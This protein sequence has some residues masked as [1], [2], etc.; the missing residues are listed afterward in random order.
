MTTEH[1]VEKLSDALRR[2]GMRVQ[3]L[4]PPTRLR[5]FPPGETAFADEVITVEPGDD[6]EP[7]WHWAWGEPIC[8]ATDIGTAV[9]RI[10]E[11]VCAPFDLDAMIRAYPTFRREVI[12]RLGFADRDTRSY[13]GGAVGDPAR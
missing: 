2:R 8:P 5:V 7:T 12:R 9:T 6:G 4:E 3:I 13:A 1:L 11:T 10:E